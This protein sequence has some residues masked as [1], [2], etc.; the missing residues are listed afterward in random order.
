MY[1]KLYLSCIVNFSP[2]LCTSAEFA[3]HKP[4]VIKAFEKLKYDINEN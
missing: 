3:K 4:S 1:S 2:G